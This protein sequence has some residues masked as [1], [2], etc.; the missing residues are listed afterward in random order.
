MLSDLYAMGVVECDNVLML[1]G[2]TVKFNKKETDIVTPLLI[3]GF[4]GKHS[5]LISIVILADDLCFGMKIQ[6]FKVLYTE[7]TTSCCLCIPMPF[8]YQ[9]M[10]LREGSEIR[11]QN[12]YLGTFL[13]IRPGS[14]DECL[15]L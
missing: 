6:S 4:V 14:S 9:Y 3:Q 2:I 1:L 7:W 15:W 8:P 5:K 12:I 13:L 11:L 10:L